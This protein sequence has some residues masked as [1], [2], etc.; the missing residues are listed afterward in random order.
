MKLRLLLLAGAGALFPAATGLSSA[1]AA[2]QPPAV[3]GAFTPPTGPMTMTRT[4]VRNLADGKQIIVTRR[5]LIRFTPEGDGYRLDGE[6]IDAEVVAPSALSGLAEIERK[7]I[8]KGLFPARLDARGM[9]Q[10]T[11]LDRDP[12]TTS[13]ALAQGQQIIAAAPLAPEAK[14]ER[15][16][17][18]G[19]VAS[20]ATPSAWPVFLFNPGTNERVERRKLTLAS[21][22]EG[23]VEVRITVQGVMA[24]GLPLAVERTVTTYLAGTSRVSREVWTFA[25]NPA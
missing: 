13:A 16:A 4:L 18:L 10:P 19:Q 17:V 12:D 7:R 15:I 9:I 1:N 14:R 20:S 24:C 2:A 11:R 22:A 5:Y 3:S 25:L 21:G 6:Q 8:D 23:E